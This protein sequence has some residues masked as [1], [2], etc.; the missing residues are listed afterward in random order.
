M[1]E[2]QR[3]PLSWPQGWK[4][5]PAVSRQRANFGKSVT[6][7]GATRPDGTREKH[8]RKDALSP[9]DAAKRLYAE[10]DRLDA[11]NVVLSTNLELR[12]DGTPRSD[13]R[14]PADVGAA[15]YFKLNGKPRCLACDRWQRVADNIAAI[16]QHIDALRRID[17]YGVGTME[18]AFAGYAALPA[19]PSDWW[20]VLGVT[21]DATS[22]QIDDAYRRLAR[23]AHPDAGGSHN[24]MAR[25]NAA[26]DEAKKA[27]R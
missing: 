17:R 2:Q 18:Q 21:P 27:G 7:E 15:V 11:S 4:R 6:W 3:Y 26:R 8:S 9:A 10:L 19:S 13:R 12:A 16:A 25:L 24:D 1:T 23:T 5:T 20:I 14:D 22:A